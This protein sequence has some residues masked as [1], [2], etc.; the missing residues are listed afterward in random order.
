VQYTTARLGPVPN[1]IE[2]NASDCTA[3]N[4]SRDDN[5]V[6]DTDEW[7]IDQ[8]TVVAVVSVVVSVVVQDVQEAQNYQLVLLLVLGR[9][10][11]AVFSTAEKGPGY[12]DVQV[13]LYREIGVRVS[14]SLNSGHAELRYIWDCFLLST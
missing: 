7:W 2:R 6:D 8:E 13:E 4:K 11:I 9:I 10:F 5:W 14:Q 12:T 3:C 1:Q